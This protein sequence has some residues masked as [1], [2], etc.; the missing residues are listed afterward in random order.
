[1]SEFM[2]RPRKSRKSKATIK[3]GQ[4]IKTVHGD[5]TVLTYSNN[6]N[7]L[8]EF[9]DKTVQP[10]PQYHTVAWIRRNEIKPENNNGL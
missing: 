4:V 5:I 10:N 3:E 9:A 8:V 2:L 1:M 6:T 7:V